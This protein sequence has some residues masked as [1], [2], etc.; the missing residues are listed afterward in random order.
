MKEDNLRLLQNALELARR[1]KYPAAEGLLTGAIQFIQKT[2][3]SQDDI[4]IYVAQ[5]GDKSAIMYIFTYSR[6][7][8]NIYIGTCQLQRSQTGLTFI[9]D[10]FV[11]TLFFSKKGP[12]TGMLSTG[13]NKD[14]SHNRGGPQWDAVN[15]IRLRAIK[16]LQEAKR[17]RSA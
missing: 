3:S 6:S 14:I 7:E 12:D 17:Q 16:L 8:N 9:P 2:Q 10:T 13:D 5:D 11:T 4:R 15:K 1:S